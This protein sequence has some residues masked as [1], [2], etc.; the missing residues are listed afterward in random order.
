MIMNVQ[1]EN[2]PEKY[3]RKKM[4]VQNVNKGCGIVGLSWI[5]GLSRIS[6]LSGIVRLSWIAVLSGIVTDLAEKYKYLNLLI[7]LCFSL[8]M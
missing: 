5:A 1:K 6:G 8:T 2:K 7:I 4:K 3:K